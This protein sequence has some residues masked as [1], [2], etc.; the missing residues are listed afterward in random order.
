MRNISIFTPCLIVVAIFNKASV[1]NL[2]KYIAL[3]C[4]STFVWAEMITLAP[5]NIE[6]TSLN[7]A[8]VV[9][10]EN[11]ALETNSISLQERLERDV[12]F[13]VV[14]DSKGEEAIS[15]L[16]FK[17]TAYVEDGIPLYRN[18][19]G[20]TDTK[21]TMTNAEL[22]FNDGSGITGCFSYGW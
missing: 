18:S 19:N 8:T 4:L 11:E 14:P 20:F 10:S 2:K 3:S 7:S 16:N 9:L 22:Q 5:I 15:L 13:S 6:E 1:L 12:S 17:S 21:F